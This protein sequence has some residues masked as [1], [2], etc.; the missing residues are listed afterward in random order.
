MKTRFYAVLSLAVVCITLFAG[1][2]SVSAVPRLGPALDVTVPVQSAPV[3]PTPA[4]TPAPS[5]ITGP[6]RITSEAAVSVA[7]RHAGLDKTQITH[8]RTDFDND[9]TVPRYEVEF[10]YSGYEYDYEIHAETGSILTWD[11]ELLD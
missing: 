11:K 3:E 8:L 5:S 4:A 10:H 1:C 9:S 7:L 2:A 6:A